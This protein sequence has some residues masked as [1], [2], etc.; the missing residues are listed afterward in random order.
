MSFEIKS[1]EI[2]QLKTSNVKLISTKFPSYNKKL[3]LRIFKYSKTAI[4]II[5]NCQGEQMNE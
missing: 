3:K 5:R 4:R 2:R 1:L